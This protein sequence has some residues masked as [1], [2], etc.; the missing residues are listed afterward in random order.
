MEERSGVEICIPSRLPRNLSRWKRQHPDGYAT[1]H[2]SGVYFDDSSTSLPPASNFRN[3]TISGNH[4]IAVYVEGKLGLHSSTVANN[5]R[6]GLLVRQSTG[7]SLWIANSIIAN[8]VDNDQVADDVYCTGSGTF[9]TNFHSLIGSVDAFTCDSQGQVGPVSGDPRLSPAF[10]FGSGIP[11]HALQ[12]GSVAI[13]AGNPD[14][15]GAWSNCLSLDARG[16]S[17]AAPPCDIG[18]YE[19]RFDVTVNSTVDFPDATPGNGICASIANTCTLRAL[20]MEASASGGRWMASVPAGTYA[21]NLPI[22]NQDGEGGDL[23]VKP[24]PG[25]PPLSLALFGPGDADAVQ[26]AGG[27]D[28]VLEI[29]GKNVGG[30]GEPDNYRPIAFAL[31]GATLRNGHLVEDPFQPPE[32]NCCLFGGGVNIDSAKVLLTDVVVRDNTVDPGSGVFGY[33]AGLNADQIPVQV[34]DPQGNAEFLP[35]STTLH[36]ERFAVTGNTVSGSAGNYGGMKLSIYSPYS[37]FPLEPSLLRNGTVSG[38][39]AYGTGGLLVSGGANNDVH[40]SYVTVTGNTATSPAPTETDGAR[41]SAAVINNSILSGNAGSGHARDCTALNGVLGLGHVVTG[42]TQADCA[43]VGDATGNQYETNAGLGPLETFANGIQGHRLL[44]GSPLLDL[45]PLNY[46]WG[47]RLKANR[48]DARGVFRPGVVQ[49]ASFYCTP[50]AIEGD[51][52]D[53]VFRDGFDS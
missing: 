22:G 6:G 12:P 1:T 43:I 19:S 33:S 27:A 53:I 49:P 11:V 2:R 39:S 41:L 45:S 29:R 31:L 46:C 37:D 25:T 38:N 30:F 17:R 24:G 14:S 42:S 34:M 9:G 16:V 50:G 52:Y 7:G 35:Y 8:N 20:F 21:L 36:M 10:D 15:N 47:T 32:E 44:L 26:I 13:N 40:L 4:G 5:R 3:V 28:R 23:D 51:G 48:T 18:A